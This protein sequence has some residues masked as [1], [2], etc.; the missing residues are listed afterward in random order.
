VVG[1]IS[2]LLGLYSLGTLE[3]N[4]AGVALMVLA[5]GLFIA[6]AF[7]TSHGVMAVGGVASLTFGSFLLFTGSPA[8][9]VSVGAIAGV[10]S[11]V[12]ICVIL[13]VWLIVRA[14]RR[15][16]TTGYD[17]LIGKVAVAKTP[18]DPDGTVLI[19]GERWKATAEG[20]KIETGEEVLVT[21]VE[22]LRLW[23]SKSK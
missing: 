17:G 8:L 12:S 10:V 18:L 23:V 14:H 7:I 16:A 13:V 15:R 6:E 5:F 9:Q 22:G 20:D 2:M 3:A 4:W 21:R 1:G 11:V 19:E